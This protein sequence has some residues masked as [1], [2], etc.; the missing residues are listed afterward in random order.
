VSQALYQ[1]GGKLWQDGYPL[2][3]KAVVD[4]QSR[5]GNDNN[6]GAESHGSWT[7]GR[8]G[9]KSGLMFGTAV[10]VFTLNIP[11][12]FLP[13]LQQGKGIR[14]RRTTERTHNTL[15]NGK[16]SVAVKAPQSH[17]SSGQVGEKDRPTRLAVKSGGTVKNG[18]NSKNRKALTE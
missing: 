18:E 1:M 8:V 7:A 4:S 2:I 17:D 16:A 14:G 9:G 10:G 12:R 5:K 13:I 15:R 11:N 6:L 3:R